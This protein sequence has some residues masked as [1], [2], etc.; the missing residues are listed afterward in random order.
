MTCTAESSTVPEQLGTINS[1]A[2]KDG[3]TA[4][5]I[6]LL[7]GYSEHTGQSGQSCLQLTIEDATGHATAF[8]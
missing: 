1:L 5:A 7:T 8:V 6:Y 3:Q 2:N 4:T